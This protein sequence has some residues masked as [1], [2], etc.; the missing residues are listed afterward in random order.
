M[1][2]SDRDAYYASLPRR[3]MGAGVLIVD[4][5]GL[6]LLVEPTYKPTWEIPGGVVETG[7]DPRTCASRE[8]REEL[9]LDLPVGRLLVID[10]KS[11][12]P[13]RGDSTMLVY[14]GGVM[15]DPSSIRLPESELRSFR[16]VPDE[17]LERLVSERFAYRVRQAVRAFR[18]GTTVE[19]VDGHA[20]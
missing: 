16:F 4:E 8:V 15:R 3:R 1:S 18:E 10:H 7:E 13:P 9:G 19:I 12:P 2:E 11:Q 5:T 17:E 20:V 6:P 14:E